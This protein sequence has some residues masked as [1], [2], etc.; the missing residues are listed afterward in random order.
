M[1]SKLDV[2]V[3]YEVFVNFEHYD[4]HSADVALII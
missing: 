1:K 3:C 2:A 4:Y